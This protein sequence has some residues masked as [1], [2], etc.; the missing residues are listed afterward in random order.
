MGLSTLTVHHHCHVGLRTSQRPGE[1]LLSEQSVNACFTK[2]L[3]VAVQYNALIFT[4]AYSVFYCIIL[5]G[6]PSLDVEV[7]FDVYTV[8]FI[9]LTRLFEFA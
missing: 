9:S 2:F 7:L 3:E 4:S 6:K 8:L 5:G 1:M